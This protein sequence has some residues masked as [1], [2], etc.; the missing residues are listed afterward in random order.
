LNVT[1]AFSETQDRLPEL[2]R[3]RTMLGTIGM[4]KF[5]SAPERRRGM[6]YPRVASDRPSMDV[7]VQPVVPPTLQ[8]E[9]VKPLMHMQEQ[10]PPAMID[11]PPFLHSVLESDWHCWSW[12]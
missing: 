2:R 7:E 6:E 10:L 11:E 3:P 4:L 12:A 8:V 5:D 9:P 1:S